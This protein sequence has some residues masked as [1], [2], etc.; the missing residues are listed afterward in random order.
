MDKPDEYQ[1]E[2]NDL[3][4]ARARRRERERREQERNAD[5]VERL[6]RWATGDWPSPLEG[7]LKQ[8]S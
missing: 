3:D 2:P 8:P 1:R 5:L 6:R 7:Q 4:R